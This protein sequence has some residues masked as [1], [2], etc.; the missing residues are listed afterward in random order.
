ML[1]VFAM[2]WRFRG[3]HR[4]WRADLLS[5]AAGLIGLAIWTALFFAT[6]SSDLDANYGL[7][8]RL[9]LGAAAFWVGALAVGLL[10]VGKRTTG[11]EPATSSLGSS[12][13]TN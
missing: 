4:W 12:R 3:D 10:V 1:S 6:D 5:L 13:S 9:T 8:Q 7:Q 2:A 11:V